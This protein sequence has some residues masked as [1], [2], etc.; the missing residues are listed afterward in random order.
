MVLFFEVNFEEKDRKK[1]EVNCLKFIFW[2]KIKL[3]NNYSLVPDGWLLYQDD[4]DSQWWFLII[5]YPILCVEIP[6]IGY[7]M[8][9][10]NPENE[11]K[12]FIMI[13]ISTICWLLNYWEG[14]YSNHFQTWAIDLQLTRIS[15]VILLLATITFLF[16]RYFSDIKN[17]LKDACFLALYLSF[18]F[19]LC[20]YLYLVFVKKSGI[21]YLTDYWFVTVFYPVFWVVV[22]ITG[23][24]LQRFLAMKRA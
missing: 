6:M 7:F 16:L 11:K 18:V 19:I 22:P 13:A 20:D 17:Y 24:I 15:N 1:N 8:Q 23:M 4:R 9:N 3:K 2:K 10:N 5:F 14:L 12:H 21:T